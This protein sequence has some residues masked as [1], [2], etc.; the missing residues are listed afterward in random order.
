MA[1]VPPARRRRGLLLPIVLGAVTVGALVGV[2]VLSQVLGETSQP[3]TAPAFSPPPR[4]AVAARDVKDRTGAALILVRREGD[5]AVEESLELRPGLVVERLTPARPTGLN[6]GDTLVVLGIPN[7]VRN[8]AIRAIVAI[9]PGMLSP[10]AGEFPRTNAGFGGY[11]ALLGGTARPL[12]AGVVEAVAGDV[13]TITGPDGPVT[14][15]AGPGAALYRVEAAS[16]AAIEP[17]DRVA[18]LPATGDPDALLVL[19]GTR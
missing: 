12:I 15:E 6:P 10:A 14:V 8:F 5:S 16:L 1:E 13:I 4:E 11:E 19:P 3:P 2:V 17:G 7:L 9:P 18:L